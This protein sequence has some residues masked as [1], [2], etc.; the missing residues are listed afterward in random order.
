MGNAGL[1]RLAHASRQELACGAALVAGV[2]A[3]YV[4]LGLTPSLLA[5]HDILLEA[6]AGSASSTVT[7]GAMVRVGSA[8]LSLALLAP[9]TGVPMYG[10]IYWWA[11]R[12]WGD[13]LLRHYT[14]GNQRRQRWMDR[15]ESFVRRWGVWALIAGPFLPIPTF[16]IEVICG[17]SGMSFWLFVVGDS[18][19][20]LLW[21]GLLVGLGYSIGHPAVH[22]VNLIGHYS[23][24]VT[25]GLIV[26]VIGL[27]AMRQRRTLRAARARP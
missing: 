25:I 15:A 26:V 23:T 6:L 2:V 1:M 7:G 22:V 4:M 13:R 8:P 17:I 16:V 27:S 21:N 18:I 11:G 5:H 20:Q 3:S 12:L 10:V 24:W 14:R 19:G 9:M